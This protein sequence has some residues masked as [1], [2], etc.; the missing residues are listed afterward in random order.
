M[1][2][3]LLQYIWQFQY[4]NQQELTTTQHEKLTIVH[5]GQWNHN[6][7][8]DFSMAQIILGKTKW[9]GNIEIHLRSSDWKKHGHAA[10]NRYSKIILH[11]V[12]QDD[13]PIADEHGTPIATLELHARI[14]NLMLEQYAAWMRTKEVIACKN[15]WQKAPDMVWQNWKV[16]M[17]TERL[18]HKAEHID[19]LLQQHNHHWEQVCWIMLCRYFGG[20]VNAESFEQI[21]QSLPIEL[22]ARHR[23]S[24]HQLEALLLGQAGLL[25][26]SFT[27][28]YPQMLF[29]EYQFLQKKYALRV[30]NK[31]PVFLRLRPQ[32]FPTVRLAQLADLIFKSHHLF[33]VVVEEEKAPFRVLECQ[34]NDYWH[35]HFKP[36]EAS[37]FSVKQLGR[38]MQS[39]VIINAL[40][41]L[42]FAF[43]KK[44]NRESLCEKA[45]DWLEDI[46]A[47]KNH[48]INR[49]DMLGMGMKNAAE[50]QA[51]IQL[52][53][54]YCQPK[55][56]LECAIGHAI[57]KQ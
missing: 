32:G 33:S 36:D 15:N 22:L 46:A 29:K 50:T 6:Q 19:K 45:I 23:Q 34:A 31:P 35:Y 13:A 16:R 53:N 48:V 39:V 8:P 54:N 38:Q 18:Q 3:R 12:W 9:A 10:D 51:M 42:L 52:T 14:S 25:H 41:P 44:M 40:S 11:V 30:I 20:S 17:L 27:D 4:F 57:L 56:C 43:G 5:P 7:G 28:A 2:E 55:R 37:S 21:A 26:R 24:I 49:W 1:N 47:E